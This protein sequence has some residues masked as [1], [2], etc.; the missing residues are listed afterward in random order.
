MPM[1]E[2][3]T[4]TPNYEISTGISNSEDGFLDVLEAF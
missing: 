3:F 1:T 4:H 2:F